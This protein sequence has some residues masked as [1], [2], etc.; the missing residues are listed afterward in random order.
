MTSDRNLLRFGPGWQEP[1]EDLWG[2]GWHLVTTKPCDS[3][4]VESGSSFTHGKWLKPHPTHSQAAQFS[5]SSRWP[6]LSQLLTLSPVS[7]QHQ[8]CHCGWFKVHWH[9]STVW[10]HSPPEQP[11]EPPLP[12]EPAGELRCGPWQTM[13]PR[14]LQLFLLPV[15]TQSSSIDSV[16]VAVTHPYFFLPRLHNCTVINLPPLGKYF[17]C[18]RCF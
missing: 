5:L 15:L 1:R 3:G 7:G 17:F 4:T 10:W 16:R 6:S 12:T 13:G 2:W 8:L 18:C 11:P 14:C 9:T